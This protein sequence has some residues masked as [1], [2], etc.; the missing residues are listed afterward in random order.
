M[1]SSVL[2]GI[3]GLLPIIVEVLRSQ[4]VNDLIL[5]AVGDCGIGYFRAR[6]QDFV[7]AIKL[8]LRLCR[9]RARLIQRTVELGELLLVHQSGIFFAA[10]SNDVIFRLEIYHRMLSA[11]DLITQL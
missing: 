10:Y 4:P 6:T 9:M 11:C 5:Q 1:A 3:F 8:S 2:R 7:N